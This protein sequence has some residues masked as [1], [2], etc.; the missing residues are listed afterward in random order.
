MDPMCF[1]HLPG[2]TLFPDP[3]TFLAD[4][5]FNSHAQTDD[6][7]ANIIRR[8][9]DIC[10]QLYEMPIWLEAETFFDMFEILHLPSLYQQYVFLV[11][12]PL[13][14]ILVWHQYHRDRKMKQTST[15]GQ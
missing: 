4:S 2:S 11:Q 5:P 13:D 9:L 1:P 14:L 7:E 8:T 3:C 15:I 12:I 6:K 10:H